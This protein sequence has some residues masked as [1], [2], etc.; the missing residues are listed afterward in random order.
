MFRIATSDG[1]FSDLKLA[2]CFRAQLLN[3]NLFDPMGI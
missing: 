2:S 1:L 3:F